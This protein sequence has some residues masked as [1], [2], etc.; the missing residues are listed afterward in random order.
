MAFGLITS[1]GAVSHTGISELTLG[2]GFGRVERRFS[3]ALD[4]VLRVDIVTGDGKLLRANV[5]ENPELY[6]VEVSRYY[7][8]GTRGYQPMTNRYFRTSSGS[9]APFSVIASTSSINR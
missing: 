9:S 2:N 6:W 5:D 4:N 7:G 3:L 1:A 8:V